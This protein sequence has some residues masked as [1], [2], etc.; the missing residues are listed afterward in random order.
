MTDTAAEL[1]E[2]TKPDDEWV[3][4]LEHELGQTRTLEA[5]L[6]IYKLYDSAKVEGTRRN[7]PGGQRAS[8]VG[9]QTLHEVTYA[10]V[11]KDDRPP[12]GHDLDVRLRAVALRRALLEE[13][14]ADA[15]AEKTAH[16]EWVAATTP[17]EP[18]AGAGEEQ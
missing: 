11:K 5:A 3:D 13:L 14:L 15:E 17:A 1:V 2:P 7:S 6:K 16:D 10:G 4:R 18:E 12:S 8:Q 9:D